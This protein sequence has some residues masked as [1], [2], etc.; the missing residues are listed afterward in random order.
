MGQAVLRIACQRGHSI[1]AEFDR[2]RP[3]NVEALRG[4][5]VM[6][7]F[8]HA[9][10]LGP[11]VEAACAAGTALV[12]G[13]T[14]WDAQ[15]PQIRLRCQQAGIAVV[16]AANFSPGATIMMTLARQAAALFSKFPEYSGG[17]EER[18]HSQK[19]DKP[20]GTAIKIAEAVREGSDDLID[21]P[22]SASRVGSEFG[23][24]TLFFDSPDDLVEI[25]HRARSRDG[26]AR[27]AVMA[28][29]QLLNR[30]GFLT[31]EQLL[32]IID[33]EGEVEKGN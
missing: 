1:A 33:D 32:R 9:E 7:D 20:S 30:S 24:H 12:I 19:K 14:G 5:D 13:S 26:F 25:S 22:I 3:M 8:S 4:A 23:L 18:H 21:A 16:H 15:L 2:R 29:E 28:A 17:I 11:V 27:G 10:A 31:F 6:I